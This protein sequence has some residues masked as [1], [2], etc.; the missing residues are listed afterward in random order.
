MPYV[1]GFGT[2]P[3]GEE[4]L[5][6]AV[7]ASYIP[8]LEV[9][10]GAAITL[11][12]TPVLA[13]Q[14]EMLRDGDAR[15]R[16]LAF[17]REI[18][19]M[20]HREDAAALEGD[21]HPELAAE[22]RRAADDYVRADRRFEEI[23]GDLITALRSLRDVELWPSSATHAVLPLLATRVGT[24]LQLAAGIDSHLRRFADWAGG[25]WLPECAY[26]PGLEGDLAEHGV[27]AFCVDQTESLGLGSL[28]HLEPVVTPEG[29]VGVPID[30]QTISLVW[31]PK[32]YPSSG[33]A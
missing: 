11:T 9:L 16:F 26:R 20:V 2:W 12:V 22:L 17:L 21:G 25:F 3:F 24:A 29:V 14:L 31:D 18:R 33:A 10:D 32:G 23:G 8:L 19:T 7:A 27:K 15:S 5:F 28:D 4:W 6:E 13:D 30:W 1:E